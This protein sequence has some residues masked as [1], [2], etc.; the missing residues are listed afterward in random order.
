MDMLTDTL[1][2]TGMHI[3]V[4]PTDTGML[5][6]TGM[7]IMA[8][9]IMVMLI[10]LMSTTDILMIT[11]RPTDILTTTEAMAMPTVTG[12]PTVNLPRPVNPPLTLCPCWA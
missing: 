12:T 8:M 3:T 4:M 9:L 1:T 2:D 5:T 11:E 10:I 6:D 7:H